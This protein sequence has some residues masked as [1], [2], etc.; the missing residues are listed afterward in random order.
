MLT[1]DNTTFINNSATESL[2]NFQGGAAI[3]MNGGYLL[4]LNSHFYNNSCQGIG[5]ALSLT[6]LGR[7]IAQNNSL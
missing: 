3:H 6:D 5:G 4:L 2:S 7:F 1:I